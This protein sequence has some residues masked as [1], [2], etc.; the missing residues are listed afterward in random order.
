MGHGAT[1]TY[2]YSTDIIAKYLIIVV[3]GVVTESV[4]RY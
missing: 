2:D 1:T 3:T 4:M